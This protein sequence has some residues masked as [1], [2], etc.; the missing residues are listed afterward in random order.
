VAAANAQIGIALAAYYPNLT[1]TGT[2]GLESGALGTLFQIPS[3]LWS[4]GASAFETLFDAGRRHALTDQARDL[5]QAQVALYRQSVLVA[6]QDVEDNLAALRILSDEADAQAAAVEAARESL[7]LSNKRYKGG[8]TTYLE[9]LTAQTIQLTN[10]RMQADIATRRCLA[11]VQLIK[12][13]G[14]G[15]STSG[16]AAPAR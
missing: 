12:A 4:L 8:V 2:V 16:S 15:W 3:L 14:G 5:Y 10:E 7:A 9:V 6:F 1:L 13:L 11:S